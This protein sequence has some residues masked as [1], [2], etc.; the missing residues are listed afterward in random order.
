MYYTIIGLL[1]DIIGAWLIAYE[2]IWRYPKMWQAKIAETRIQNLESNRDELKRTN[3]NLPSPPY[4]REEI[5]GFQVELDKK[6]EVWINIQRDI[7][8]T[9]TMGHKDR[10]IIISLAGLLLLTVGFA[11]QIAGV[12]NA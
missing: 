11:L 4:T 5:H 8:E 2:F 9:N 1:L 7:V 6:Y 3:N 12:I 10:A